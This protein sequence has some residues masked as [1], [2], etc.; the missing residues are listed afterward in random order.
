MKLEYF[1]KNK[2]ISEKDI[3]CD[4]YS[5]RMMLDNRRKVNKIPSEKFAQR[6]KKRT[7]G[8]MSVARSK[9]LRL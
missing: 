5:N 3:I 7:N 6:A 1:V 8:M 9:I 4:L 2:I